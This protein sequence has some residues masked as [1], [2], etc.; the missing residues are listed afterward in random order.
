MPTEATDGLG[1]SGG[2]RF[3]CRTPRLRLRLTQENRMANTPP[4]PRPGRPTRPGGQPSNTPNWRWLALI[5]AG[6]I[7][8]VLVLPGLAKGSGR[9]TVP[10]G[11]FITQVNTGQV[12]SAR[13]NNDNGHISATL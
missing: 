8:A 5:A 1:L 2:W 13:V 7:L 6:L 3:D 11:D 10:Y 4:E 9:K 12:T